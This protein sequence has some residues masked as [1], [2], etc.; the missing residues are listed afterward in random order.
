[1]NKEEFRRRRAAIKAKSDKLWGDIEEHRAEE[2][3]VIDVLHNAESILEKLDMTFEERTSLS[4]TDVSILMLATALQLVRIYCLPK[5][6][7]KYLDENRLDHED[8]LIKEMD[9]GSGDR[10]LNHLYTIEKT[11]RIRYQS[12]DPQKSKS[13]II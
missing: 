7:E 2:E 1:M 11:E 6:Q 10:Y 13:S 4:K 8:D 12:P 3:R 9:R 5:F